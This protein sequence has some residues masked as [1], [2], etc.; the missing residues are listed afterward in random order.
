MNPKHRGA[1]S[2]L[3]ATVW[4]LEQGYEVFTNVSPHGDADII[5]RD[6]NTGE[7]SAVDV[8]TAIKYLKKDGTV[9]VHHNRKKYEGKVN[10]KALLVTVDNEF[11][12]A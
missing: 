5:I 8:T 1:L 2:E 3:K 7:L 4:L 11:I 6:P 12:W 10:T 9:S